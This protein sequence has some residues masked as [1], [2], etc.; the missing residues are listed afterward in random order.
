MTASAI[1]T[2]DPSSSPA[3][4]FCPLDLVSPDPIDLERAARAIVLNHFGDD[5]VS[6]FDA[7]ADTTTEDIRKYHLFLALLKCPDNILRRVTGL[8]QR[9]DPHGV[10]SP[11]TDVW[12]ED[13][14]VAMTLRDITCFIRYPPPIAQPRSR[15]VSSAVDGLASCSTLT[16][17]KMALPE[18]KLA[19]LDLKHPGNG[20]EELWR[21]K[22][23][24]LIEGGW[25]MGTEEGPKVRVDC[26]IAR[27][28][29]AQQGDSLHIVG[30]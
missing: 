9:L 24:E 11:L 6:C 14:R 7:E 29:R 25:Y 10:L 19:D 26:K 3:P 2:K 20:K 13:F 17:L 30:L 1:I 28:L 5:P 18:A 16:K 12:S 8:Q 4:S 15:K 22:E 27:D 23:L 21:R